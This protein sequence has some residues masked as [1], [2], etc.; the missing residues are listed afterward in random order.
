MRNGYNKCFVEDGNGIQV[1]NLEEMHESSHPFLNRIR[2]FETVS[3][4]MC[5]YVNSVTHSSK[6]NDEFNPNG[7]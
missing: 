3:S 2:W 6:W 5:Q 7:K 1:G 4:D